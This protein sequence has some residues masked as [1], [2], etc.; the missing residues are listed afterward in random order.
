M[1]AQGSA[2]KPPRTAKS[3]LDQLLVARELAHSLDQARRLILAGQVRSGDR[4]L[5]KAGEMIPEDIPVSVKLRE[6]PY[7][8]WGGLKLARGIEAFGVPVQGKT[9]L[10]I[11]ASTGGFTDVLLQNG[12]KQV[13]ALDVGYGILDWKIR[14]D[15]RVVVV[16]RTNFRTA[17]ADLFPQPFD[18]I[19]IDVS[20][21]SL[22]M[23][24]PK[25]RRLLAEGG[26][27]LALVKPQFEARR[28]EVGDGGIVRDPNVHLAVLTR[29]AL[30]QAPSGLFLVAFTAVP[31]VDEAKNREF[32]SRWNSAGPGLS[33]AAIEKGLREG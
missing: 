24:L 1:S 25:A 23:I 31:V 33:A 21:I 16:E 6:C 13:T 22:N 11:G 15:P 26:Q 3:R 29:L 4:V 19:T 32:I 8:S 2:K 9:A 7:V 10:D 30:E 12:V 18:L 5:D 17:P 20:F 27:I 14:S 28:D